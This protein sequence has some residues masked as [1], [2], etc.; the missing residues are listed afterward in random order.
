MKEIF[1][2]K[3][4]VIIP[5]LFSREALKPLCDDITNGTLHRNLQTVGA[6]PGRGS[7]HVVWNNYSDTIVGTLPRHAS[8]VRLAQQHL[9]TIDIYHWH[10]KLTVKAPQSSGE[11]HWHQDFFYWREVGVLFQDML[12]VSVALSDMGPEEGCLEVIPGSH[13]CGLIPHGPS[14][15]VGANENLVEHLGNRLGTEFV[16]LGVGDAVVFHGNLLHRSG[17]NNGDQSRVLLH[18]TYNTKDNEPTAEGEEH[19]RYAPIPI[20]DVDLSTL[21]GIENHQFLKVPV[22]AE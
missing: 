6:S 21:K 7:T 13:R 16:P 3:G 11:W 9:S 2:N 18:M 20:S 17:T 8:V 14:R 15:D 5:Q 19:H 10:S 4:Y 22:Q 1:D 12:T